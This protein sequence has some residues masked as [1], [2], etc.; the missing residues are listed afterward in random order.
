MATRGCG[1][2]PERY[3]LAAKIKIS[4]SSSCLL[5]WIIKVKKVIFF[6]LLWCSTGRIQVWWSV[7][8]CPSALKQDTLWCRGASW[9]SECLC[10]FQRVMEGSKILIYA[11]SAD[12]SAPNP[13]SCCRSSIFTEFRG[14]PPESV[15]CF[16]ARQCFYS[17]FCSKIPPGLK[18]NAPV[19]W[20]KKKKVHVLCNSGLPDYFLYET[21]WK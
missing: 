12:W 19:L 9:L 13:W 7:C 21:S 3:L 16:D 8:P 20:F 14:V 4:L 15:G 6:F 5:V 17:S 1:S 11:V 10:L 2:S 18:L